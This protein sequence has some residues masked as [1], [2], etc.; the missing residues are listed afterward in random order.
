MAF[1]SG[2]ARW[3]HHP[4]YNQSIRR[5]ARGDFEAA[6]E[7]FDAV[8]GDVRDPAHPD[9]SLA[10]VH[11]NVDAGGAEPVRRVALLLNPNYGA[12]RADLGWALLAQSRAP[13]G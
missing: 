13:R 8:L 5:F 9:F 7:C 11:A 2:L 3:G 10:T 1:L 12:A 6:A 4:R